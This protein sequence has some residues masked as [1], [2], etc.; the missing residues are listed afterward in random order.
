MNINR[1]LIVGGTGYLG[2][3]LIPILKENF[4]TQI[5]FTGSKENIDPFYF[6]IDF[7]DSET[8]NVIS[9]LEFDLVIVL[10]SRLNGLGTNDLNNSDIATNGIKYG[11]FLQYL[12]INV[13]V[14]KIVYTSS[15]TVYDPLNT[16]PVVETG[17]INPP[18]SYGLSKYM[19]EIITNFY[20]IQ[21]NVPGVILRLPGIYGGDKKSGFIYNL[22]SKLKKNQI[23]E[24]QNKGLI[25]WETIHIHDL[26]DILSLFLEKY[27]WVKNTDTFNIGYGEECDFNDTAS[28][29]K[30]YLKSPINIKLE[31]RSYKR[32]YLSTDK[33]NNIINHKV[34]YFDKL[35]V[36]IN[37]MS[38]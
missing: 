1:I 27:N 36:Y 30:E 32:F 11:S 23:P 5:F 26:C 17:I 28:F 18:N 24:L 20:C 9:G 38:L 12:S 31:Q 8:F 15:M 33:I 29:I 4:S 3:H 35:K 7:E 2:R 21:H 34:S 6:R 14:W 16:Q 19:G 10:A 13:K 37:E 25:Y 22:I